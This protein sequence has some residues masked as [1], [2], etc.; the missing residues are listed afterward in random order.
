MS[1]W[2]TI[3]VYKVDVDPIAYNIFIM[4]C[5]TGGPLSV[6]TNV[7]VNRLVDLNEGE[8]VFILKQTTMLWFIWIWGFLLYLHNNTVV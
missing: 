2:K 8:M 1:V 5:F 6:Y 7:Y 3:F 4:S